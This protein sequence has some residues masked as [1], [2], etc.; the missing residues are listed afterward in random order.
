MNFEIV[1]VAAILVSFSG[2]ASI[3]IRKATEIK[4]LPD[5][6]DFLNAG[7]IRERAK[8]TFS[9]FTK[10]KAVSFENFLHKFLLRSRVFFLKADNQTSNWLQ[11]LREKSEK[12]KV[13]MDDYWKDIKKSVKV[14]T[15]SK[16]K[17]IV[18]VKSSD[19][20]EIKP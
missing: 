5:K 1:A 19:A 8:E 3:A 17:K 12:R 4:N 2:M 15:K 16:A 9:V 11:K 14:S 6:K 18:A 20:E 13:D 10:E 7:K